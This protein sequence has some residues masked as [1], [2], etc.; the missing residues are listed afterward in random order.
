MHRSRPK[1]DRRSPS[2]FDPRAPKDALD[3][4]V[5]AD[6]ARLDPFAGRAGGTPETVSI[7]TLPPVVPPLAP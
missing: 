3:A 5:R 4:A 1:T 6:N 7:G 2:P